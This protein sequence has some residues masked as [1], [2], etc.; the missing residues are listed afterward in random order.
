MIKNDF[1]EASLDDLLSILQSPA[2]SDDMLCDATHWLIELGDERAIEPLL[3]R[4]AD[5]SDPPWVRKELVTALG[6]VILLSGSDSPEARDLQLEI[7]TSPEEGE[8][9][10][11][12]A[13]LNL[14]CIGEVRAVEP[15][16][17]ILQSGED[18]LTY[19]C[20]AAL[21]DIGDPSA[22]DPLIEFLKLDRLLIP[23]TAAQ[24]LGKFGATAKKALPALQELAERGN[25][26]ERRYA[27]EAIARIEA[28]LG[29]KKDL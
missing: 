20:V 28:D 14:G 6:S 3:H 1:S 24:G 8:E 29:L 10:R 19:A 22:I 25:D 11:A 12:A 16:L 26:A 27:L 23:Q 9:V 5:E 18:G 21:G 17:E 7:L 15:L 4:L 13:A 2:S